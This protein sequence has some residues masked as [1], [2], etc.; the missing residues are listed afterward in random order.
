M[1]SFYRTL[2]GAVLIGLV[3]FIGFSLFLGKCREKTR[4]TEP[5]FFRS[6][7]FKGDFF[8]I[9]PASNPDSEA[10]LIKA[11]V[12]EPLQT[13][14]CQGVYY[15]LDED[16]GNYFRLQHLDI[17]DR[18]FTFDSL[19][20]FTQM[21]RGEL[22]IEMARFEEA[23]ACLEESRQLSL[24]IKDVNK[25]ADAQR[26]Q[27]RAILLQGGYPEAIKM[28]LEVYDVYQKNLRNDLNPQFN[29][30][31]DLGNAYREGKDF[32]ES[33][34][35]NLET[36]RFVKARIKPNNPSLT[37][38]LTIAYEQVAQNYLELMMPDSALHFAKASLEV[39]QQFQ[40]NYDITA[41]HHLL[42][43]IYMAKNDYIK[44][45]MY[46]KNAQNSNVQKEN[47]IKRLY[48]LKTL[49]DTY[50]GLN[51][52]DSALYYFKQCLVSRDTGLLAVLHEQLSNIALKQGKFLLA[53]TEMTESRKDYNVAFNV[54]KSKI[55]TYQNVRFQLAKKEEEIA[56][57][58]NDRKNARLLSLLFLVGLSLSLV[59]AGLLYINQIRKS[60]IYIQEKELF[61]IREKLQQQALEQSQQALQSQEAQLRH[62]ALLLDLKNQMIAA[63]EM[64]LTNAG[65]ETLAPIQH[66]KDFRRMRILT[67]ADWQVFLGRFE[68]IT[69]GY[70][71]RLKLAF[72]NL[73][74]SETRLFLLIKLYFD[75]R[76]ISEA[77]G[78]SQ[79]S[80]WRSRHRLRKKLGLEEQVNLDEYIQSF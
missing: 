44:A 69:P 73:T 20:A 48:I 29:V 49:G 35:W 6:Q 80:V 72:P 19:R 33:L 10:I 68:Q 77:S 41:S 50:F 14:A 25:A 46:V 55:L 39:R 23:E 74:A 51:R 59:I 21:I 31:I 32:R 13:L 11:L 5:D 17:F 3:I 37:G 65:Q 45:L 66:E 78:I 63:L 47:Q 53:L 54:E 30:C 52:L 28:L 34:K 24:K 71:I 60:R 58:E 22:Y 7:Q 42:S 36:L 79:E 56:K 75:S 1:R 70:I 67:E 40:N 9:L 62:S 8:S 64:Q 16:A 38:F 27:A 18:Y 4:Q 15:K 76:E 61:A 57:I 43:R 26:F 2:G 12:P